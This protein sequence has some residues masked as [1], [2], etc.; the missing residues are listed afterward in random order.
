M[1]EIIF[2]IIICGYFL[3]NTAIITGASK[4]FS[5]LNEDELLPVT[6]IVAARD[7]ESNIL[8]CLKALDSQ[9]YDENKLEIIIAD[10]H[11]TDGT[12]K[13]IDGFIEGK[14]KFKKII[15]GKESGNLRGKANAIASAVKIAAGEIIMTTD[16]DCEANPLW[17]KTVA[18]YYQKDVG[19]VNSYTTQQVSG[20][21]SG[22]QAVDFIYLLAV[23]SGTI[24]ISMPVSCIGNNM[25][26]RKNAYNDA[27]GYENL[28]FSV[29]EDSNLLL[30]INKLK[31][32]K[33][34]FP[35][36]KDALVTSLP[37]A[38]LK[39]LFSQKKRWAAG[40]MGVPI[41][42][43][44]MMAWALASNLCIFLT[45][46]FFSQV[47]LYLT[48]FKLSI[49]YFLLYFVHKQL[50]LTKNLRYFLNFELYY[51]LYVIVLPLALAFN[52][53]VV[54]KGRKY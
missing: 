3:I 17:V 28:P 13:I 49:D 6:V 16:A 5:R 38:D 11:S 15:P 4:K 35:L 44:V 53:K 43:A 18:S 29:T 14:K 25:S 19:A 36:D 1:F 12:G 32:Y 23:A 37:C 8:R 26:Y 30:A 9:I 45:P 39:T 27:G 33:L 48:F 51:T 21:F 31:K 20:G 47:C 54:W 50:G 2:L 40:G 52:R 24:N 41:Y 10:D 7:E 42:G 34:I 46:L 22:M